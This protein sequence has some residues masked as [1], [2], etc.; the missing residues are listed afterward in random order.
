[1]TVKESDDC[2]NQLSINIFNA[3]R[4]KPLINMQC[5]QTILRALAYASIAMAS[6]PGVLAASWVTALAISI[7]DAPAAS[8][9]VI[10]LNS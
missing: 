10:H 3:T 7:S 4:P 5:I 6:L 9:T 1:M 2:N 8:H